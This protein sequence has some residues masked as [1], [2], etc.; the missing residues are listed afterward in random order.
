VKPLQKNILTTFFLILCI[1]TSCT[2]PVEVATHDPLPTQTPFLPLPVTPTNTLTI[3]PVPTHTL[4]PVQIPTTALSE[5]G[6]LVE[7]GM[8]VC[9]ILLYH[10]ISP[11]LDSNYNIKPDVFESQIKWLYDNHYSTITITGL[12]KA[13]REGGRIPDRPVVLTF[14]DGYLE[15]VKYA[16]P[17]LEKYGFVATFYVIAEMVDTP[18]NP[19]S[20]QLKGLIRDGWEVGSHSYTHV[21]LNKENVDLDKE[22]IDSKSRIEEKVGVPVLSFAYPYGMAKSSVIN[23]SAV[24]LGESSNQNLT[25]IYYLSR[26]EIEGKFSLDEFEKVLPWSGTVK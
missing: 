25:K 21:D 9:P 12:A 18:G 19:T 16:Y 15:V 8:I 7:P 4:T 14:D 13:L 17:I 11:K 1:L 26:I 6:I 22:I 5:E 23:S 10:H 3:T 2:A 24:G 20:D